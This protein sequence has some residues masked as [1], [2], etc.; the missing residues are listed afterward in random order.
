MADAPGVFVK[1][2]MVQGLRSA[3]IP[4]VG[5]KRSVEVWGREG[6]SDAEEQAAAGFE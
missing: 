3:G 1:G 5:R 2:W 4:A 6:P